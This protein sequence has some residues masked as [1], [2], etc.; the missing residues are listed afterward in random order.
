MGRIDGALSQSKRHGEGL[1]EVAGDRL[2]GFEAM[3]IESKFM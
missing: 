3:R 2:W 1:L